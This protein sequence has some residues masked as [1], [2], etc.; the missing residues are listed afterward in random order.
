MTPT[1][2]ISKT[3]AQASSRA[4]VE[5]Q[6]TNREVAFKKIW[7]D[8]HKDYRGRLPDGTL[9]VMGWAKYGGGLVTPSSITDAELAER[10]E[11]IARR[12]R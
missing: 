7:R 2:S 6:K 11:S 8:T 9:T 12:E 1:N 5:Q 10:L 4:K 3:T